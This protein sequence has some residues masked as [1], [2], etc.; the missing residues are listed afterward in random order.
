M[1]REARQR[2]PARKYSS[3]DYDTDDSPLNSKQTCQSN[4]KI[5]PIKPNSLRIQGLELELQKISESDLHAHAENLLSL[6]VGINPLDGFN[7]SEIKKSTERSQWYRSYLARAENDIEYISCNES[8]IDDCLL[9]QDFYANHDYI[10]L[11]GLSSKTGVPK[12]WR[13]AKKVAGLLKKMFGGSPKAVH[14]IPRWLM[15]KV[16]IR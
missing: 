15:L 13:G 12:A 4:D 1:K 8:D 3:S 14:P 2:K 9:P 7:E 10:Y 5:E 16:C 6:D 11:S